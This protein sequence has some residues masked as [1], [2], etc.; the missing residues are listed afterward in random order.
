MKIS[1]LYI[2]LI[3][4][5]TSLNF[6]AQVKTAGVVSVFTQNVKI[7]PEMAESI[8]R[9][10]LTKSEKFNV[11][12][13]LDMLEV[14]NEQQIDVSNC[15]G[16]N[17]LTAVG[18]AASL[19]KIVTGSIE[20]LGKKIVVTIKVLDVAT[21]KYSKIAV[22][23]F[24]FLEEEIQSMV[25]ITLNKAL[26]IRNDQ[27]MMNNFV[28]YNQPPVAPT[29]YIKN[30]GPR[31]GITF[32]EGNLGKIMQQQE[33][34]GG[35]GVKLPIF[36]QIG[37]QFEQAYL[38]AGTF[39]VL[40]EGLVFLNGI[41]RN[42]FNPSFAFLNGFRSSKNGWELA[43]GPTFR[44]TKIAEGYYRGDDD[45]DMNNWRSRSQWIYDPS[46]VASDS[47]ERTTYDINLG[48]DV[49]T[50]EY[51]YN[52]ISNPNS[53]TERIDSR[54]DIKLQAGFVFALGKTF[55]SGY[56]N[57][58]VNFFYSTS[59]EGGGYLGLSMGFNIAKKS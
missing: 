37:Y 47:T 54:G 20:N 50:G 35:F 26:G 56:L 25:R 42:Q 40:I 28:Y 13:K 46:R 3:L 51:D 2:I 55:H 31:M 6:N 48:V 30:G 21:T 44:F 5:I 16:K 43:F 19:D 10:E 36:S 53:Y 34:E 11:F 45:S 1:N 52:Y 58:P 17:C 27:E 38:S 15:F 23:E 59:R 24:I 39:Q 18:K 41:E 29:T 33:S 22:E 57:I 9:I 4:T 49:G 32:L 14:I 7:S 8:L 12:D